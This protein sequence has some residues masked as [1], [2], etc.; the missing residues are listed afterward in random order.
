[1]KPRLLPTFIA[2]LLAACA[3]GADVADDSATTDSTVVDVLE[4]T[5]PPAD[6]QVP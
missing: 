5:Q 2:L 4:G 3:S 6:S 1:M